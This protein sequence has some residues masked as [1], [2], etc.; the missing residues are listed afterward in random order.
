MKIKSRYEVLNDLI[1]NGKK[2]PKEWK[3]VFGSDEKRLSKDYYIFNPNVGIYLLKE[4]Q[5]NPY[6][7]LGVGGKIARNVDENVENEISKYS[8]DFGL[9]QGDFQKILKNIEN[10]VH[11]REILDSAMKGKKDYGLSIPLRGSAS[12]SKEV[13]NNIKNNL[14]QKQKKI[15]SKF[16]EIAENEGLYKS[17]D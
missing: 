5:K 3:A 17:Y 4:H 16:E 9:L 8:G 15:D 6:E 13:F 12:G 14:S 10:G 1:K 2:H 11:P 7:V